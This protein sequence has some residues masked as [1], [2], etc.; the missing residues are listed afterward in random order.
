M[1]PDAAD[2]TP[3]RRPTVIED[4]AALACSGEDLKARRSA[5]NPFDSLL[6]PAIAAQPLLLWAKRLQR[7]QASTL[8]LLRLTRDRLNCHECTVCNTLHVA[9]LQWPVPLG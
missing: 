6:L 8:R 3:F 4:G 7:T 2:G 5:S 9:L 1:P